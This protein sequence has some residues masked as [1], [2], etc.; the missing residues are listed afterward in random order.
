MDQR[1]TTEICCC[2]NCNSID[3][4]LSFPVGPTPETKCL[5]ILGIFQI[6]YNLLHIAI[7]LVLNAVIL[8]N[9]HT[10]TPF[11]SF[12]LTHY[13]TIFQFLQHTASRP[14]ASGA[15]RAKVAKF[16][17]PHTLFLALQKQKNLNI[18]GQRKATERCYCI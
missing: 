6:S 2:I 17:Y 5:I 14:N 7:T 11:F 1:K 12:P 18:I 8:E 3:I 9:S 13:L 10:A 16:S 4:I 15:Y